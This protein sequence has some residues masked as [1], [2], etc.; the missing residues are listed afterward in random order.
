MSGPQDDRIPL[1]FAAAAQAGPGEALLIEEALGP[2]EGGLAAIGQERP[3]IRFQSGGAVAIRRHGA[4]CFCCAER[5][6]A[7]AALAAL[8]QARALGQVAWFTGVVA[9]VADAMAVAGEVQSD[10]VAAARFR[11]LP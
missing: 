9:V 3:V 2:G 4:G 1:R 7:A 8:F 5:G 10:R 11:V 6:S